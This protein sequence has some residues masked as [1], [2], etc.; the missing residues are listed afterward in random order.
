MSE[1]LKRGVASL[2]GTAIVL[3]VTGIA[4]AC[5]DISKYKKENKVST[6]KAIKDV[7]YEGYIKKSYNAFVEMHEKAMR[8]YVE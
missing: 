6:P 1:G 4:V 8:S 3:G 5:Y 7:V 2:V